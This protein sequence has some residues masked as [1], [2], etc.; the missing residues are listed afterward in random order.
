MVRYSGTPQS[1]IALAESS[2]DQFTQ[3]R[4]RNGTRGDRRAG[5]RIRGCGIQRDSRRRWDAVLMQTDA[6]VHG[7]AGRDGHSHI[8]A[9]RID[10]VEPGADHRPVDDVPPRLLPGSV[11]VVGNSDR[12]GATAWIQTDK[13]NQQAA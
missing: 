7:S 2:E 6:H 8:A 5:A 13:C 9:G 4:D 12:G 3:A 11:E 1:S 10:T